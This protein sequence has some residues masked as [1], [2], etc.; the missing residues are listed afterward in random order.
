M[1]EEEGEKR[2]RGRK[3]KKKKRDANR[4]DATLSP[5]GHL[6]YINIQHVND[7]S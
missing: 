5:I 6:R 3:R 7:E 2:R 1:E 4:P